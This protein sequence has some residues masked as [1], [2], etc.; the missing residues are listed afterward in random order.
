M[1]THQEL[2]DEVTAEGY[3]AGLSAG[4][5][6]TD[7]KTAPRNPEAYGYN[8]PVRIHHP[9]WKEAFIDG[10]HHGVNADPGHPRL[11]AGGGP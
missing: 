11:C 10:W 5:T 1:K 8:D 6:V 4:K 3:Q 2:L 7:P 9:Y